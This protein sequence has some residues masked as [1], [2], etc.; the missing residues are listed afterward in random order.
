MKTDQE[1]FDACVGHVLRQGEPAVLRGGN[2]SACRYLTDD[3]CSCAIGGPLVAAGLYSPEI[4]GAV[5]ASLNRP[6]CTEREQRKPHL[7]HAGRSVSPLIHNETC[8]GA[9]LRLLYAALAL[10]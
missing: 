3:G 7:F 2:G 9:F 6:D 1:I 10:E 8:G 4:E 5:V